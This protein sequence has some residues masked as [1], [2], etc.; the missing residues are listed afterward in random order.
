MR[1]TFKTFTLGARPGGGILVLFVVLFLVL[2]PILLIVAIISIALFALRLIFLAIV[3]YFK[4]HSQP[5]TR[6]FGDDEGRRNVRVRL[7]D[8]AQ[9]PS[10]PK[11][12]SES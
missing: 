10:A 4:P 11:E 3:S 1:E 7:P 2:F 5:P 12:P 6:P 9:S 8:Q